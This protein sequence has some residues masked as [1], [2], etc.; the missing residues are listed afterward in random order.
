MEEKKKDIFDSF[1]SFGSKE[2]W[3]RKVNITCGIHI[4]VF[5][6]DMWRNWGKIREVFYLYNFALKNSLFITVTGSQ[7]QKL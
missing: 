7:E 6:T 2:K 5:V 3:G 1:L 4:D